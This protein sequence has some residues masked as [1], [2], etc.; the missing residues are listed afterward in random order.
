MS[1]RFYLPEQYIRHTLT[2]DNVITKIMCIA[3]LSVRAEGHAVFLCRNL[4]SLD[5]QCFDHMSFQ[6]PANIS[7]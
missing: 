2:L 1:N 4:L 6:A 3:V 7:E 5:T